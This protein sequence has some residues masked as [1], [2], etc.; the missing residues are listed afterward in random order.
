MWVAP[1]YFETLRIP[2]LAGRDF[3][4]S[5]AGRPRVALISELTARRHFPGANPIG[6][7]VSIDREG[8]PDAW[9]GSDE[10]YEVV[11][12]VGDAKGELWEPP[13]PAMYLN[14]FQEGRTQQQFMLRTSVPP[15]AVAADTRKAI[16]EVIRGV[17]VS[18]VI[19][20]DEQVDAALVP[21][22]LIATL[23]GYFGVLAVVLAAMGLYGLLAFTVARRIN[24]IGV[25]MALGATAGGIARLVLGDA[26]R[27]VGAGLVAGAALVVWAHPVAARLV[28]GLRTPGWGVMV[29]GAASVAIIATVAAYVP[30]RRAARVDPMEAL[31]HE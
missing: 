3:T 19:T 9:Y 18:N 13:H 6:R 22:R 27:M 7:H 14:M 28:E 24:E 15:R 5:D 11:G 26:G 21:E 25:R 31:R 17:T 20:L 16:E 10:P 23:S 8:R 30:A 2:L 1:R 4:F 12:V 29:A